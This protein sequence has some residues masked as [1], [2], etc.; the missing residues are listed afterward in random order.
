VSFRTFLLL[1]ISGLILPS[2]VSLLQTRPGY[3]DSDYYFAG[4]VQLAQGKG[5]VEP[6]LWNYLDG[7]TTLPHPSHTYWMP[8]AS[9]VA[10]MG[11]RLTGNFDY[12]SA[13]L[14]FI[15]LAAAVPPITFILALALSR[16]K[17]LALISAV[18][19]IFSVYHAPFLGVTDNFGIYMVFGGL[20]F[21]AISRQQEGRGGNIPNL[22]LGVFAG[23]LSLARTD[24][25]LWLGMGVMVVV[26]SHPVSLGRKAFL[27][28]IFRGG[29]FVFLGF[30]IVMGPWYWRNL[31][32][33]NSIMA[34]GSSRALWLDNYD[35]TFIYP[36]EFLDF[37]YFKSLGWEEILSDRLWALKL[38]LQSGFAAHGSI[39]LFPFIL[40]GVFA[41]WR[42]VRVKLAAIAWVILFLVMT[43]LFPFAGARGAFFHAGAALQPMW[44]SLAPLGLDSLL[45][46]L[47]RRGWG[48]DGTKIIFHSAMILIALMLTVYVVYLRLHTLGWGEG[49]DRYS[50]VESV[51]IHKGI[52]AEDIVIVRNAPGYYLESGRPAISIPYGGESAI[53]EVSN[54]FGAEYLVL[55]PEAAIEPLRTLY[56]TSGGLAAF[57]FLGEVDGIRLYQINIE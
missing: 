14:G 13:R 15:I 55:E 16:R 45:D 30:L 12:A 52:E 20:F 9:I 35:Q 33:F 39:I 48:N 56:Q 17:N 57:E 19:S 23:I 38:N 7:T 40:I 6:Y 51:L 1:F 46:F 43:L 27:L 42:D 41:F 50:K 4:G 24:G 47:R 34:P 21:L 53:A 11:M 22:F 37:D 25:L 2:V 10:A 32:V 31:T 8:L 36:P 5:F 49:E 29:I 28:S 3:L 54:V 18:L 26:F 44:W